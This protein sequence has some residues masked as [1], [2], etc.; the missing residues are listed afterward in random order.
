MASKYHS[1]ALLSE[2]DHAGNEKIACV[3]WL[4]LLQA[5]WRLVCCCL[6]AMRWMC[7]WSKRG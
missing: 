5:A 7:S 6:T 4:L 3:M 1:H 2:V